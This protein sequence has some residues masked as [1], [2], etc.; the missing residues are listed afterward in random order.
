MYE[1]KWLT[2]WREIGKYIG[3]SAK[4]AHRY[5]RE[6][7]PFFRDAG[8]RPIAKPSQIDEWIVELNQDN[9]DDKTWADRGIRSALLYEAEKENAAKEFNERL[10]AA[11]RPPRGRF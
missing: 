10:V 7:M 11:Q 2:G 4:T 3:K 8:G 9:Y 5:S 6:G 1:E